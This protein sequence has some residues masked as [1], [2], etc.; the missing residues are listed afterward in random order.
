MVSQMVF[1]GQLGQGLLAHQ[2]G[3]ELG[4]LP[5]VHLG[6]GFVDMGADHQAQHRIPQELQPLIVLGPGIFLGF[7][8][9]GR[10]GQCHVQQVQVFHFH[11]QL[12]AEPSSSF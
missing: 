10:M 9:I 2:E 1:R 7:I 4:Q 5:F 6:T 8:G 12:T 11:A 3:P